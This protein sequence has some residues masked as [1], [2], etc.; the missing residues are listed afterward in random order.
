MSLLGNS[1]KKSGIMR[2]IERLE[3]AE[4]NKQHRELDFFKLKEQKEKYQ[5]KRHELYHQLYICMTKMEGYKQIFLKYQVT[6]NELAKM[7]DVILDVLLANFKPLKIGMDY[8]PVSLISFEAPLDYLMQ[9][10][11]IIMKNR[12]N[13]NMTYISEAVS[14]LR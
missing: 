10:K 8:L 3:I 1:F 2:K 6:D 7:A 13:D 4:L 5:Q 14:L 11:E 9:Y 12:A